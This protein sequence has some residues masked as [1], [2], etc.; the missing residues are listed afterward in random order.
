MDERDMTTAGRGRPDPWHDE[1]AGELRRAAH[2]LARLNELIEEHAGDSERAARLDAQSERHARY[3]EVINSFAISLLKQSTLDD[4]LWDIAS[5]AVARLGLEDCVIY[6][7]DAEAGVLVQKAAHGAK[8]PRQHDILDPLAIPLGQGI[9]GTVAATGE[10]ALVHDTRRTGRYIEDDA[11]RLSELAVPIVDNGRVIGVIDSEHPEP[12][13]YTEEH[14]ELFETIAAMAST[15]IGVALRE[16]RLEQTIA[17]LESTKR[18]LEEARLRAEQASLHKSEFL[19]NMSHEIRTPLNGV[20][21]L[22]SL[23]L[24][25]GLDGEQRDY[26]ETIRDS[27][28]TLLTI[29]NDILDFSKIEA[30]KLELESRPFLLHECVRRSVGLVAMQARE[31]GLDVRIRIDES[32]PGTVVGDVTRLS[33]V[34]ANLLSNALKFTETGS[35]SVTVRAEPER[36][37]DGAGVPEDVAVVHFAVE[38]TGIG[39]PA[40]R[41]AKLFEPFKQVDVSTARKFGGTGLGLAICRSL[42]EMQ[43]G[44]IWC[45]A[46]PSGGSVFRFTIRVPVA[47]GA[48]PRLSAPEVDA[49]LAERH[50]LGILVV[51]D[52]AVNRKVTLGMLARL[53]YDA[54]VAADG[55]EAVAAVAER[56]YD[57]VLMDVQMPEMGGV[58]AASRVRAGPPDRQPYIIAFTA[59]VLSGDEERFREAGMDSY[60]SKPIVI[61]RLAEVLES[62]PRA[63]RPT[64]A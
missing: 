6:L 45:D 49:G 11:F 17:D 30:G 1:A 21:G 36:R 42:T 64:D 57:V 54:D 12:D 38:D 39:I 48:D 26:V 3:L 2:S 59:D 9:V 35:I 41:R 56:P 63:E 28:E 55:R 19:A 33:Q 29:I 46:S 20:L 62:V 40:D 24:D 16:A 44:R 50:P 4:V 25:T 61:H 60:L 34:L 52:N 43:G 31:K 8:N 51:E 53:G 37:H 23:L 18:E 13:F 10:A 47:G 22:N 58:E 5:N 7:L 15:R 32:V 27:G 14:L